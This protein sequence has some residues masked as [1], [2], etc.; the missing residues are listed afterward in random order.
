MKQ[1]GFVDVAV[2]LKQISFENSLQEFADMARM[3]VV[4]QLIAISD[5]DYAAGLAR[6]EQELRQPDGQSAVVPSK[7]SLAKIRG[8]KPLT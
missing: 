1:V 8:S 5:A 2:E 3:R 7:G 4:S 6:I